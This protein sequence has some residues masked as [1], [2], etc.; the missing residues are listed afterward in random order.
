M[1]CLEPVKKLAKTRFYNYSSAP[2]PFLR[3]CMI[4]KKSIEKWVEKDDMIRQPKKWLQ[5]TPKEPKWKSKAQTFKFSN[6][7]PLN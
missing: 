1:M 7:L 3:E 5:N 2:F 6:H 4:E